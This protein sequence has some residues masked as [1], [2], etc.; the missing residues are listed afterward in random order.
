MQFR[1]GA[2]SVLKRRRRLVRFLSAASVMYFVLLKVSIQSW[3]RGTVDVDKT[4]KAVILTSFLSGV[5]DPQRPLVPINRSF[6]YMENFFTSVRFHRIP[7]VVFYDFLPTNLIS[8]LSS[9]GFRFEETAIPPGWSTNDHR[10]VA[11]LNWLKRQEEQVDIIVIAD[12][13]DTIF[14]RNPI[15]YFVKQKRSGLRVFPSRD[16]TTFSRNAWIQNAMKRCFSLSVSN[17]T[18]PF[19]NAGL[20]GGYYDEIVCMLRCIV[21][22]LSNT[23][24]GKG[25]CNMPAYNFCFLRSGCFEHKSVDNNV[26]AN[27]IYNPFRKDCNSRYAVIH[28]K[29]KPQISSKAPQSEGKNCLVLTDDRILLSP[30][31]V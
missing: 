26:V 5:P 10:F 28:D 29:C 1:A 25:N 19:Y 12:I 23:T 13:S 15:P 11:M 7:C 30:C 31:P 20:W 4:P 2:L 24:I 6:S 22:E 16:L 8:S 27:Y 3:D 17:Y 21:R 9:P 18:I 14:I